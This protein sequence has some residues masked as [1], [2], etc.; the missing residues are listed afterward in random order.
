MHHFAVAPRQSTSASP[1]TRSVSSSQAVSMRIGTGRSA[2]CAPTDIEPVKARKH[3]AEDDHR[4]QAPR[5]ELPLTGRHRRPRRRTPRS[6]P[7]CHRFSDGLS[8][9]DDENQGWLGHGGTVRGRSSRIPAKTCGDAAQMCWAA[10]SCTAGTPSRS[11]LPA[12][13]PT[14][15]GFPAAML[16]VGSWSATLGRHRRR[17][18]A[19][20]EERVLRV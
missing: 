18:V 19:G 2:G 16:G 12:H 9:S 11:S 1:T 13:A 5:T 17:G 8:V 10:G 7:R 6:G 4:A 14:R 15:R 3:R 20:H